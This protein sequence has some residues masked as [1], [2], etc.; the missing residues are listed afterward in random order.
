MRAQVPRKNA[1]FQRR[2]GESAE[3]D[4]KIHEFSNKTKPGAEEALSRTAKELTPRKRSYQ[5]CCWGQ[6]RT[7]SPY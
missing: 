7:Y 1:S 2:F 3:R 6:G 4:G 5:R